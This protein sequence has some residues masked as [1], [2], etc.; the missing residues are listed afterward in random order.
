MN[1]GSIYAKGARPNLICV[2]TR[3]LKKFRVSSAAKADRNR[4]Q[5]TTGTIIIHQVLDP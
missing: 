3:K 2:G 1:L 5:V 4:G